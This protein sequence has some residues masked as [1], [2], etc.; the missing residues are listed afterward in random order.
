MLV[1]FY[2]NYSYW[3]LRHK[4]TFDGINRLIIVNNDVVSL[5]IR[6]ELYSAWIEWLEVD[7]NLKYLQAM[8]F[9]GLDVIGAGVFTGDTYF[10][11]NNWKLIVDLSK[12]KITGI[13]Y[14]DNYDTAFYTSKLIPQYPATVSA[15][16]N[17]VTNYQNIVTGDI[18]Q[19]PSV[20]DIWSYIMEGDLTAAQLQKILLA[21]LAG[22]TNISGNNIN[23][24]DIAD[25][26]NR[27]S[28][29]TSNS[30]RTNIIL[31]GT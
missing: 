23:F 3:E 15:L 1:T 19:V 14:S 28:A 25:T 17:S 31:D 7:D 21:A 12:V 13:L 2:N 11:I 16:V 20:N 5:D 29:T 4:V 8:R 30:G 22:K 27:I 6:Q 18:S 9:T 10:L 24:R 26:K